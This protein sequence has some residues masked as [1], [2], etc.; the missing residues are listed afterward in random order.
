M[1]DKEGNHAMNP[2]PTAAPITHEEIAALRDALA[3]A[4]PG[5]WV[6]AWDTDKKPQPIEPESSLGES[7]VIRS[8]STDLT[9]DKD[10]LVVSTMYYD[11][12]WAA[13]TAEDA[14]AIVAAY[15]LAP[16]LLAALDAAVYDAKVQS[17]RA[18]ATM[19]ELEK[20][21]RLL[22]RGDGH[23]SLHATADCVICG[24]V[25]LKERVA[26]AEAES[27]RLQEALDAAEAEIARLKAG[28]CARDQRTTQHCADAVAAEAQ[29]VEFAWDLLGLSERD[30][31]L[32]DDCKASLPRKAAEYL[33]DRGLLRKTGERT[34][35][36][37][38][39]I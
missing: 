26:E 27:A 6:S 4:T 21:H 37:V 8:T 39:G 17:Q 32:Y 28:G 2:Q 18:D 5:E 15:N 23:G 29:A 36:R 7:W 25:T 30:G 1:T 12:L 9:A 20:I 22:G 38:E 31:E 14:R 33:A 35:Q 13:C 10:G 34:W 19:V 3:K 24:I 11:G 16:K